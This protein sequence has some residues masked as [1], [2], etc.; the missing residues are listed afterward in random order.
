MT[1]KRVF[2]PEERQSH[3]DSF[4]EMGGYEGT[5]TVQEYA[6]LVEISQATVRGWF[7]PEKKKE[8]LRKRR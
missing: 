1:K 4:S 3:K 6:D 2:T 5:I 7:F 8:Y